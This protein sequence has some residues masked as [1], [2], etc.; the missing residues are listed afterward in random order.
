MTEKLSYDDISDIIAWLLQADTPA[1]NVTKDFNGK[2]FVI[3]L[4]LKQGTKKSLYWSF[5]DE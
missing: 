4:D 5:K 3:L 1:I 2:L